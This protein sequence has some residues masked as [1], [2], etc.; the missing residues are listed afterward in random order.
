[1]KKNMVFKN[2]KYFALFFLF[3]F[4]QF[5]FNKAQS[6]F[7][8]EKNVGDSVKLKCSLTDAYSS[9]VSWRK[10]DGVANRNLYKLLN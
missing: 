4:G 3:F 2:T 10:T 1:M 8:Q 7:D 6:S 9:E 5:N